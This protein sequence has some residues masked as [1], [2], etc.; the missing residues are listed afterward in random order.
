MPRTYRSGSIRALPSGRFQARVRY[1][2]RMV[3]APE[4]FDTRGDANAWLRQATRQIAAGRWTPP[5]KEP[6][7][8]KRVPAVLTLR[9][10]ADQ[11]LAQRDLKPRTRADY[12]RTM[13]RWILPDLGDEPLEAI[14]PAMVRAWYATVAPGRAT[15]RAHAYGLLRT[16]LGTAVVDELIASNPCRIRGGG[17]TK[18]DK[19]ITVATIPEVEKIAENM[20]DRLRAM[21]WLAAW[22]GLRYGEV[23]ELRR[24]DIDLRGQVVRVRRGVVRVEGEVIVDTP[25]SSAGIRDVSIPP[26]VVPLIAE[27]LKRHTGKAPGSLLFPSVEGEHLPPTTFYGWYFPARKA[28]GRPD[29]RFHDLRHTQATLAAATGASLAEIMGRLGH[30]TPGAAM[31][32]QHVAADRDRAIA[33][34]LSGLAGGDVVP[35]RRDA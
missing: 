33:E 10:Y 18:R 22:C 8:A 7:K 23:T 2:G 15:T 30:S 9:I 28:A 16:I 21:I 29:L 20:P 32:Y 31:R 24:S 34:A 25:K 11:W 27:H 35:L 26:H 4:T 5:V 6:K 14:K 12:R 19:T 17:S 13:D 3:A 1:Q